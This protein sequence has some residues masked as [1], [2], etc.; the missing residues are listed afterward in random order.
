M[1]E[2]K[3]HLLDDPAQI[4]RTVAKKLVTYATGAPVSFA[5]RAEIERI[6]AATRARGH[7]FRSLIHAVTESR[8]F[9]TR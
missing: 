7:V 8:L 5:D 2:L 4:A 6:V 9:Q 3:Q 1:R